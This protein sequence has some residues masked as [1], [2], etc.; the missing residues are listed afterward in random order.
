MNLW[1]Q[2]PLPSPCLPETF[3]PAR[4]AI[5]EIACAL[6][7]H[8][9]A[10]NANRGL[11]ILCPVQWQHVYKARQEA[12]H[13]STKPL[14]S[15][16]PARYHLKPLARKQCLQNRRNLTAISKTCKMPLISL[17]ISPEWN[18]I[19]SITKTLPSQDANPCRLPPGGAEAPVALG[20][21]CWAQRNVLKRL[22]KAR[23]ILCRHKCTFYVFLPS[24]IC[25]YVR[26]CVHMH[27]CMHHALK[28]P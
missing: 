23:I 13:P 2:L 15:G 3:R 4:P 14:G 6:L 19:S 16:A 20:R 5:Q 27:V 11:Q 24:S 18:K 22:L 25:T 28:P 26:V 7:P 12:I 10:V 1:W 9:P 8:S 17:F 21:A